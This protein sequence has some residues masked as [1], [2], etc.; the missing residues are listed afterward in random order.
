M[1]RIL[2]VLITITMIFGCTAVFAEGFNDISGHWAEK[3]ILSAQERGIVSGDG[4]GAFRP[5]DTITRAEYVKMLS[6]V[7]ATKMGAEDVPDEYATTADWYSKY[8]NFALYTYLITDS[9]NTISGLNPG[10]FSG[11]TANS[12]I[13]RW[14]M[15]YIAGSLLNVLLEKDITVVPSFSDAEVLNTLPGQV[16]NTIAVCAEN[17]IIYGDDNGAFRP[18][19]TGTRAKAV[20]IVGRVEKLIEE[21][22]A[23]KTAEYDAE[24]KAMEEEINSKTITYSDSEIPASHVKVKFEMEGGKSFT[25]E[26]YPEYAPQTVAN[27]VSLVKKGFYDGLTFHRVIDDFVAQ[28]GDPSG[29]GT[30]MADNYIVGEFSANGFDNNAL[31][32]EEGT[33]SMAR[34]S[35]SNNGASCQFFICYKSLPELDG[36]Y[37]AFGKVVEGMDTVKSFCDVERSISSMGELSVPVT[38]IKIK[39]ATVVK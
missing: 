14:E 34:S 38:P 16:P 30:G 20:V 1:K 36:N 10:I 21:Y 5:N 8:Y 19:G 3:D 27:F 31:L 18:Y 17:G 26:L 4:T 11:D 24:V 32:H 35:V 9:E 37:A 22:I 23:Q 29:D 25:V 7:V 28:G 39:K 2:A 6:A 12:K 15:A 13:E 33:I